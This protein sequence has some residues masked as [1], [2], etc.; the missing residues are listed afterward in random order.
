MQN[1]NIAKK[2]YEEISCLLDIPIREFQDI[3][4][5]I[6]DKKKFKE[7]YEYNKKFIYINYVKG[8]FITEDCPAS[9]T[10]PFIMIS[11][12]VPIDYQI[13]V[14]FHEY[15]HYKC[16]RDK[17][18][19]LNS[20]GRCEAHAWRNSL[21]LMLHYKCYRSLIIALKIID[22]YKDYD[23]NHKNLIGLYDDITK[24]DIRPLY[25]KLKKWIKNCPK[26]YKNSLIKVN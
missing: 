1:Y 9:F 11:K 24:Y 16:Y 26:K 19:C 18:S 14:F 13:F 23:G 5:Y 4:V 15:G 7:I 17:C 10:I 2:N 3:P 20:G 21:E 12:E 25:R 22:S 8:C 6:F